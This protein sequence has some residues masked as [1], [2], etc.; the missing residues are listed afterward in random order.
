M[1]AVAGCPLSSAAWWLLAVW[2]CSAGTALIVLSLVG[3]TT[4]LAAGAALVWGLLPTMLAYWVVRE[5]VHLGEG[6]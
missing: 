6:R 4:L 5:L 1:A 2:F 3:A